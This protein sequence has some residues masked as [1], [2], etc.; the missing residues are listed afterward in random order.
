MR[1]IQCPLS[2]QQAQ[3]APL[4]PHGATSFGI[5]SFIF[6]P[7]PEATISIYQSKRI[8]GCNI[9]CTSSS[10]C[11][12]IYLNRRHRKR[13]IE[14]PRHLLHIHPD[15]RLMAEELP[16]H[17]PLPRAARAVDPHGLLGFEG[18]PQTVEPAGEGHQVFL[19]HLGG[20]GRLGARAGDHVESV[21][22]SFHREN[23]CVLLGYHTRNEKDETRKRVTILSEIAG[24]RGPI[25]GERERERENTP[26]DISVSNGCAARG[27]VVVGGREKVE[28]PAQREEMMEIQR[29][30]WRFPNGAD[31][32]LSPGS[33][34]ISTW[35]L[36]RRKP[37]GCTVLWFGWS[38]ARKFTSHARW[39]CVTSHIQGDS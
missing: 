36:S 2:L 7:I 23:M 18:R 19:R 26:H 37:G 12:C 27:D 17:R 31:S 24:E 38:M 39:F 33:D 1:A 28:W 8:P 22:A 35:M 13:C 6:K 32:M 21:A 20:D 25:A 29:D 34:F 11:P 30:G 9:S 14:P 10:T 5:F 3:S 16:H 15:A 4:A